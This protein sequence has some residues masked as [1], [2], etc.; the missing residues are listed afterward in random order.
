[1]F[2]Y[3]IKQYRKPPLLGNEILICQFQLLTNN[4]KIIYVSCLFTVK[5]YKNN[6]HVERCGIPSFF[7]HF[8]L[9][10]QLYHWFYARKFINAD[11]DNNRVKFSYDTSILHRIG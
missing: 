9:C 2:Y 3:I 8:L 1:T 5:L 4:R 10:K 6:Q 11:K 7:P